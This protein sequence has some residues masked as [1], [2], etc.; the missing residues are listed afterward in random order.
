MGMR[1]P[2][3]LGSAGAA[4]VV[5]AMGMA[6]ARARGP[7]APPATPIDFVRDIQPI[8]AASCLRCHDAATA[9]GD[10]R[11]DTRQGLLTGGATGP[12]VVPGDGRGSRLYQRLVLNDPRKRMPRKEEPLSPIQI[13][14]VRLWVD[15][16]AQ[17]PDGLQVAGAPA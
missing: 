4:I 5:A 15:Q 11:L 14:T 10:L 17:W 2:R 1:G 3:V 8:L 13:E 16:G 9:D 12:A 7:A 6:P